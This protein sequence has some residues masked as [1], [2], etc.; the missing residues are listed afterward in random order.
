MMAWSPEGVFGGC[1]QGVAILDSG[2]EYVWLNDV[3][4][5]INGPAAEEHIG[6][7]PD[8]LFPD[9]PVHQWMPLAQGVVRTGEPV[10]PLTFSSD[11]EA[12]PTWA[13]VTTFFAVPHPERPDERAVVCLVRDVSDDFRSEFRL[14]VV[15]DAASGLAAADS[16]EAA[17]TA[18]VDAAARIGRRPARLLEEVGAER[19][20]RAERGVPPRETGT[21]VYSSSVPLT[22]DHRYTL[23]L[24]AR[25]GADR[26]VTAPERIALQTLALLA[27][28]ALER[29]ARTVDDARRRVEEALDALIEAVAIAGAVRDASG[30]IVDFHLIHANSRS[31]DAA[32][33]K[34]Q[35]HVGAS[36]RDLYPALI[37]SGLFDL[38]VQVVETREPYVA[39]EL[40]YHDVIDGR[41]VDGWW[42]LRV[43]PLGDGYLAASRDVTAEVLARRRA[44]ELEEQRRRDRAGAEL[45]RRYALPIRF[46]RNPHLEVAADY[47]PAADADAVGG[48]WYDAFT[49]PDRAVMASIGDVAG[50]GLDAAAQMVDTR[51]LLGS[52]R[53]D[54]SGPGDA[55]T[56]L[57][58]MNGDHSWDAFVTM[59]IALIDP[60]HGS[61]RVATAGHPPVLVRDAEG[62]TML[63]TRHPP[64]GV[65]A[66]TAYGEVAHTFRGD[67]AVVVLY[68]DGLIERRGQDIDAN[69]SALADLTASLPSG[70]PASEWLAALRTLTPDPLEDDSCLLVLR[71]TRSP[72]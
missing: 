17:I 56:H 33:R 49:L 59:A 71:W 27:G 53:E 35:E 12:E 22:S 63:A 45:L 68:T 30:A 54:L 2:L 10:G 20:V 41:A 55:L 31:V 46:P 14:S 58:A 3:M 13:F 38:Y 61:V 5:A 19:Q 69:L 50:H 9:L 36:I 37:R 60:H 39:D 21:P 28:T 34:M 57:D 11:P 70:L 64:L 52:L 25:D 8:E 16:V 29:V 48:D 7:R 72:S 32:G 65:A 1:P 51:R 62:V 4:A 40:E 67:E 24:L 23:E 15:A 44:A 43:T 18:V 47:R 66:G 26:D 42:S 6:R